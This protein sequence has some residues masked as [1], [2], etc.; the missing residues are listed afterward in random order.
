MQHGN[1]HRV[2]GKKESHT[3]VAGNQLW[4]TVESAAKP[5]LIVIT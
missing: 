1:A 2:P 4:V 3:E 5:G